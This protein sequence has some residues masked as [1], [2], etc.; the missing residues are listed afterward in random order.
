MF[1]VPESL[2]EFITLHKKKLTELKADPNH[3]SKAYGACFFKVGKHKYLFREAKTTG[4]RPGQ[5][6]TL[7]KRPNKEI[8]PFDKEDLIDFLVVATESIK[9]DK[10][11]FVFPREALLQKKI[12]SDKDNGLKGKLAFRVFP[13]WAIDFV[14]EK[15]IKSEKMSDS[16]LKTQ[17][18]QLVYFSLQEK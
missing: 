10:G 2:A 12:F 4:T 15:P 5:F 9:G 18:W 1:E 3:E 16:A 8:E 11:F 6:L 7:W 14:P 13:P 17:K